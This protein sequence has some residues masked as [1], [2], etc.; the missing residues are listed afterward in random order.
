MTQSDLDRAVA[1]RTGESLRRVR[2]I[3]FILL[4]SGPRRVRRAAHTPGVGTA[5]ATAICA[6]AGP[7]PSAGHA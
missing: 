2:R 3:G 1:R 4:P 5:R 6:T 7:E